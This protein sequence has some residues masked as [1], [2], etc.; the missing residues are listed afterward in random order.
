MPAHD[1][2]RELLPEIQVNARQLRDI[3]HD[4]WDA[5]VAMNE[6]PVLFRRGRGLVRR[7]ETETGIYLFPVS[8]VA[9]FGL[10]IRAA[11]W[12]RVTSKGSVASRPPPAVVSDMLRFPDARLPH[13]D[14]VARL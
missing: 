2:G 7:V 9:L 14:D 11:D 3:T 10:L 4:A 12:V 13:A 6:P 5:L 1:E 8:R